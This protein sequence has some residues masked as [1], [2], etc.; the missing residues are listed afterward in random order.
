MKPFSTY[1]E[2]H[3]EMRSLAVVIQSSHSDPEDREKAADRLSDLVLAIL[4]DE[5]VAQRV[6]DRPGGFDGPTGAE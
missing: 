4:D 1:P 5:A 3:E 2:D 6:D